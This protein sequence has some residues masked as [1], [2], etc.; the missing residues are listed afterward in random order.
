MVRPLDLVRQHLN[1]ISSFEIFSDK[2]IRWSHSPDCRCS[3]DSERKQRRSRIS[4][5]TLCNCNHGKLTP[6]SLQYLEELIAGKIIAKGHSFAGI[7]EKQN[8]SESS[9]A[10]FRPRLDKEKS[11][12][13]AHFLGFHTNMKQGKARFEHGKARLTEPNS[14]LLLQS[15]FQKLGNDSGRSL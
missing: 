2:Q 13:V 10:I 8:E 3:A 15:L 11:D 1:S 5:A 9:T 12:S 7:G 14:T 4:E 6:A